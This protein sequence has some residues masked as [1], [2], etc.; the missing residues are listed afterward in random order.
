MTVS[1][2][3]VAGQKVCVKPQPYSPVI[4]VLGSQPLP[5]AGAG[6]VQSH[7]GILNSYRNSLP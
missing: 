4:Q 5:I 3:A 7:L 2:E 1:G 6:A